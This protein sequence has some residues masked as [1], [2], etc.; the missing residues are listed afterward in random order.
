MPPLEQQLS[1]FAYF[2][3]AVDWWGCPQDTGTLPAGFQ[4]ERGHRLGTVALRNVPG[5]CW[6]AYQ[7]ALSLTEMKNENC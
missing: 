6:L 3:V 1:V 2:L 4:N 5:L 7:T